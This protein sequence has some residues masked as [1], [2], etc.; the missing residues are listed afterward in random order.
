M[1]KYSLIALKR[2][3]KAPAFT[4][5]LKIVRQDWYQV[6]SLPS[7]LW[8]RGE[9]WECPWY[10]VTTER[11][12]LSFLCSEGKGANAFKFTGGWKGP[13]SK[14]H[15]LSVGLCPATEASGTQTAAPTVNILLWKERLDIGLELS[16]Y[17]DAHWSEGNG[18]LVKECVTKEQ[19]TQTE[20]NRN[21]RNENQYAS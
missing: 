16:Y 8:S 7:W 13:H 12:N 14:R 11:K 6:C 4:G 17:D 1:L 20:P 18:L 9:L 2:G 3:F 21:A 5:K 19:Q 10:L 15:G